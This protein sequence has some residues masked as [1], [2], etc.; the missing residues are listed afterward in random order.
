MPKDTAKIPGKKVL[1]N[2]LAPFSFI[3]LYK[4]ITKKQI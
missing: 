1:T 4:I 3:D 2:K